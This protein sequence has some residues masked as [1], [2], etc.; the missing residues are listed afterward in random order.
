M[1]SEE[2]S[3]KA[4]DALGGGRGEHCG[5]LIAKCFRNRQNTAYNV[6]G[7]TV[8]ARKLED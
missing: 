8:V 4:M 3:Y 6:H 2:I 1:A 7:L 5:E